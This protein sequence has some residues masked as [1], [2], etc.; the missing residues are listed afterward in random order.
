MCSCCRADRQF[1]H[2]NMGPYGPPVRLIDRWMTPMRTSR[3]SPKEPKRWVT[4]SKQPNSV[5]EPESNLFKSHF[6]SFCTLCHSFPLVFF[7]P[8]Y[9]FPPSFL[10]FYIYKNVSFFCLLFLLRWRP[11]SSFTVSP[12]PFSF[13]PCLCLSPLCSAL[14]PRVTKSLGPAW[15]PPS[16]CLSSPN[17]N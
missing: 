13:Y 16:S 10:P 11:L 17:R 12:P 2:H 6:H 7:W 3:S 15:L 4:A 1:P 5:S 8:L 14:S 9:P